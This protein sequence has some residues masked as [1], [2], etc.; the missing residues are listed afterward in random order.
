MELYTELIL[1]L[2]EWDLERRLGLR[3]SP[4]RN[5]WFGG[6]WSSVE[7]IWWGRIG[8]DSRIGRPYAWLRLSERDDV[9]SAV[10]FRLNDYLS[11]ELHYDSR[12]DDPWNVRAL[13]NL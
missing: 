8:L 5:V 2:S 6:E 3:W 10:G 7:N 13:I 9:N 1:E 4:W 12:Y 11:I